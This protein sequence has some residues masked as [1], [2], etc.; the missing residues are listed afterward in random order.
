M[1]IFQ[2]KYLLYLILNGAALFFLFASI[3]GVPGN[4]DPHNKK[5]Q[6]I[7]DLWGKL[8]LVCY[9]GIPAL[10]VASLTAF[11]FHYDRVGQI[12]SFLNIALGFSI[13]VLIAVYWKIKS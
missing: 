7:L 9:R 1:H 3:M 12:V 4:P 5:E 11:L 13:L 10:A 8:L 6:R 2:L